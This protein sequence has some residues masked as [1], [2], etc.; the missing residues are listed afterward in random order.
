MGG[1]HARSGS[2]RRQSGNLRK[3]REELVARKPVP[4]SSQLEQLAADQHARDF[5]RAGADLVE[6]G[7]AQ[8]GPERIVV[9][10]AVAAEN[11]DR[12]EGDLGPA[13]SG[14]LRRLHYRA[15]LTDTIVSATPSS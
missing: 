9:G 11:L 10:V 13:L 7:V 3:N 4:N 2:V 8:Q 5:A 6:L 1:A 14:G 15:V 12:V